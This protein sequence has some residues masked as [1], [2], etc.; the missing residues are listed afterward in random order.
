MREAVIPVKISGVV[1]GTATVKEDGSISMEIAPNGF[2]GEL[3][4][5]LETG[6]TNGIRLASDTKPAV[7]RARLNLNGASNVQ[8]GHGNSQVNHY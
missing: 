6:L 8:I 1:V 4:V 5:M 7:E 3:F 2:G